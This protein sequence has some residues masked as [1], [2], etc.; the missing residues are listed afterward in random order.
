MEKASISIFL[1][2]S[3][4]DMHKY[5]GTSFILWHFTL[6]IHSV[7]QQYNTSLNDFFKVSLVRN[8]KPFLTNDKIDNFS[9]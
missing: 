6:T 4:S 9:K 5:N 8:A 1:P 3:F 7:I 2:S